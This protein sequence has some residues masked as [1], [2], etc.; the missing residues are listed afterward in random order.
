MSL[1]FT[2]EGLYQAAMIENKL[3]KRFFPCFSLI[4]KKFLLSVSHST[5]SVYVFYSVS[6]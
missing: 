4:Q 2:F 6:H 3:W 5:F 1:M